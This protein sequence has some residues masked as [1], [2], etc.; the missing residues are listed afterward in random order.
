M[1]QTAICIKSNKNHFASHYENEATWSELKD[2]ANHV[3]ANAWDNAGTSS[4]KLKSSW[5]CTGDDLTKAAGF[6]A[7]F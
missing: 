1:L 7:A 2:F 5:E 6:V 4:A 3:K